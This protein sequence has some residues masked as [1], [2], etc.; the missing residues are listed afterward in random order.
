MNSGRRS[1]GARRWPLIP[2]HGR[3]FMIRR[4]LTRTR[5]RILMALALAVGLFSQAQRA[6]SE[7]GEEASP[8]PAPGPIELVPSEATGSPARSSLPEL[9]QAA[10]SDP[11]A[12]LQK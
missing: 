3:F 4:Q 6:L 8:T 10:S 11:Y 5:L 2:G 12:F 9:E 7:R 1:G